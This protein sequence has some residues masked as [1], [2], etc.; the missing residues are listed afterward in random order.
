ML[1]VFQRIIVVIITFF[2]VGFF[3]T[4]VASWVRQSFAKE[5]LPYKI[6]SPIADPVGTSRRLIT[7][8]T[9]P[10]K[11]LKDV[12]EEA[13]HG[14]KGDYAIVIIDLVN[15]DT[16]AIQEEKTYGSASLYKLWVMATAFD[17][18]KKGKLGEKETLHKAIS[19]LNNEFDISSDS[20]EQQDG[21]IALTVSQ[22][23]HQMI[24]ISHNYAALLLSDRIGL[25]NVSTFLKKNGF[26]HSSIGQ[27]PRTTASDIA[28]FYTKLYRGEIVSKEASEKMLDLLKKQQLNDR[29]PKYLPKDVAVAHKTG[30]LDYFKHDAGIVFTKN[31]EYVIVVLS[32]SEFPQAAAE[33]MAQLSKAVYA[34][35][36][37]KED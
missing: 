9:N 29:I 11:P 16:Y 21:E 34:Y 26:L 6:L 3:V 15:G 14:S 27:P 8:I 23:L 28:T 5:S 33:R 36:E 22:A 19:D 1:I 13:M 7:S 37:R 2:V 31:R 24:T 12:V 20:A 4:T 17:Q 10:Q 25:T 18:I 35:F 30:E 32:E